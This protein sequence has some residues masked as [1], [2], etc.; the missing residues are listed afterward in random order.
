MRIAR[1]FYV[2]GMGLL[3]VTAALV[4]ANITG[5]ESQ[6]MSSYRSCSADT[7]IKCGAISQSELLQKYDQNVGD[8]KHVY[9]H[10]GISRDDIAGASSEVVTGTVYQ[11]GR[12]VVDGKTIATDAYSLS[13]VKFTSAGTPRTVTINGTTY[14]EGPSMRIFT[15]PVDAFVLLRGGKFYKAILSSC[16]NP[17]V[18]TPKEEPTPEPEPVYACDSLQAN[19]IEGTRYRFTARATAEDGAQIESYTFTFGDGNSQT[20]SDKTIEHTYNQPGAY[21]AQVTVNILVDGKVK[22]ETGEDCKVKITIAEEV[23]EEP[24]YRCDNLTARLIGERKFGYTLTYTAEDGAILDRV[25]YNFGDSTTETFAAD[26]ATS[27]EHAYLESGDF[28]TTATLYFDVEENGETVERTKTCEVRV[29][30]D[31][32]EVPCPIPGKEHLP[33]DSDECVEEKETPPELPKTGFDMFI[34]GSLGAGSIAA[35]GH[36]WIAS[37]RNLFEKMLNR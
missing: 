5:T 14:Y 10:Y 22:T 21:T 4:M 30:L 3:A 28:T 31:E 35:A 13:R 37:R 11:D 12:V 27:V 7:I 33:K 23:E 36:Y 26:D 1:K 32:K 16:G 15:Q 24:L 2:G 25:T 20:T 17:L 34:G 6:A 9:S 8:V 19:K 29:S 18:A